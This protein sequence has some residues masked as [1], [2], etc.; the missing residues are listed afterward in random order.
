MNKKVMIEMPVEFEQDPTEMSFEPSSGSSPA[1]S[2]AMSFEELSDL[3]DSFPNFKMDTIELHL[4][5]VVGTGGMTKLV[6]DLKGEA[7]VKLVL[8]REES[9]SE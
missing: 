5:A 9:D 7:G 1:S 2:I 3:A 6:V 4:K 8:K